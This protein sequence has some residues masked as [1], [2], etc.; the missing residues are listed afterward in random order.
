MRS[1]GSRLVPSWVEC[2]VNLN[3]I[4]MAYMVEFKVTALSL[5]AL[6][7]LFVSRAERCE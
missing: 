7:A 3:R 4:H 1:G 6:P 5:A 2:L